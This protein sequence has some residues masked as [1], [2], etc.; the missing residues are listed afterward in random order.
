MRRLVMALLVVMIAGVLAVVIALLLRL[1]DFKPVEI[2]PIRTGERIVGAEATAERLT[3]TLEDAD[4]GQR[5]I[6]LDGA[7]FQPLREIV[8]RPEA[9]GG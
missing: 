4:G 8:P 5:V 1:K 2:Q 6:V 7:N 9:E 3:L